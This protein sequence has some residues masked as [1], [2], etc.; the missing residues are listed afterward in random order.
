MTVPRNQAFA[1]L[2]NSST[3]DP[4]TKSAAADPTAPG[5]FDIG[6]AAVRCSSGGDAA[7]AVVVV[8]VANATVRDN[9]GGGGAVILS[10]S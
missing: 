9:P 7:V 3:D 10:T 4:V 8:V 2:E 5:S 1:L 6:A